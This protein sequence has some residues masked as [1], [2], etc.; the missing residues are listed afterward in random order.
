M[1]I[2]KDVKGYEGLYQVSNYGNV[3]SRKAMRKTPVSSNGYKI[4]KLCK[5][6]TIKFYQVHRL[7][8]T[9]FISNAK[10]LPFVN[11]KDENKA[12]NNANNLEW[13]SQQYNNE[14][15]LAKAIIQCDTNGIYIRQWKSI[16]E[17]SSALNIDNSLITKCCK[18]K[19]KTAGGYKW[20][21][22]K[23]SKEG[24]KCQ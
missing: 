3:K 13:C 23:P 24:F 16:K 9:A 2:W 21:Y 10:N 12:N 11:H 20:S 22:K 7:V 14:Y 15:S 19:R 17:A 6:G 8:A 18:G 5:N 4:V 1:E